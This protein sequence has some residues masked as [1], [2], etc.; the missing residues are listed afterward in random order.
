MNAVCKC[1]CVCGRGSN[2]RELCRWCNACYIQTY[3]DIFLPFCFAWLIWQAIQAFTHTLTSPITQRLRERN[4]HTHLLKNE[5]E[6]KRVSQLL[7][8]AQA[9]SGQK[10]RSQSVQA[11]QLPLLSL[12]LAHIQEAKRA[13][14]SKEYLRICKNVL[15]VASL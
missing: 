4:I 1:D 10:V 2:G 5:R 8:S 11:K 14:S 12:L 7:A 13:H 6:R 15:F 9:T 3:K